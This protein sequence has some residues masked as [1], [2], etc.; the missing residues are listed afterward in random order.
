[1]GPIIDT[2]NLFVRGTEYTQEFLQINYIKVPS[3]Y[4]N[5]YSL[6]VNISLMKLLGPIALHQPLKPHFRLS[7]TYDIFHSFYLS[8]KL[9]LKGQCFD[10]IACSCI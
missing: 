3:G 1:M 7:K 4:H 5:T 8:P 6:I 9:C 2:A 10:M